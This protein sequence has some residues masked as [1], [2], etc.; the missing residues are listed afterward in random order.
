MKIWLIC[1]YFK[2]EVGAPSA[3]LS[4]L[5]KVW[6]QEG[7]HVE[8]LTSIPN[9][10]QGVIH[11]TYKDKGKLYQEGF[12]GLN[13]TRYRFY[14]TPNEGFMKKILSHLHFAWKVLRHNW[15]TPAKLPDIM[16]VSSPSFFV[17]ISTW[18]LARRHKRPFVFEVRDL[19]PGIFVELGVLKKGFF[20]T[21]VEKLEL[22]LY[23]KATAVITVTKGFAK[24]IADR[25]IDPKKLFIVT[26]GVSDAEFET[27]LTPLKDG[28][29][30]RLRS[31]LQINPLT[32]VLLYIGCHGPS[33]ALGQI[34]DAARLMMARSDVL[35]LFVGD[36]ADK[37]RVQNLAKGMPN[38]M[39]VDSQ[40]KERVWQFYNLAY[41]S[42]VPLKD[43]EGFDTFIPSKMFEIWA[44]K[45]VVMGCVRGEA[46]DIMKASKGATVT[47]PENP[48]DLAHAI[49]ML[50]D[51]PDRAAE[52]SEHGHNYVQ[53]HYL[54]SILGRKY[55]GVLEKAV[56][57]YNQTS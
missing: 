24:N 57:E 21:V 37:K 34:V 1:Q 35:F 17:V 9:H 14:V 27:A 13:V 32:K 6:Q 8:V 7:H 36:G 2:P 48:E 20:L 30:D 45:T 49:Q 22:F 28:S 4:G 11:E 47:D 12:E 55:L 43:I 41:A 38:I 25:G 52:L 40:P 31:E 29:V 16:V 53:Q 5:A 19:W 10:P 3:R 15:K 46:A 44:S 18:L 51:R 42:F 39:F 26:N 50:I 56:R 23:R 54:H 33:Q